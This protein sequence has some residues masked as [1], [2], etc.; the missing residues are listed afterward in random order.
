MSNYENLVKDYPSLYGNLY[1][2]CG[3]GWYQILK[4]LSD[5]I[6]KLDPE[7]K[8]RVGQVKEKFG[9]LRYY[10]DDGG[11]ESIY[12]AITKA[13]KLSEFTCEVCGQPGKERPSGWIKTLC[14]KHAG[15]RNA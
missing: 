4:D 11:S 5:E 9:T 6:T 1:F 7:N 8:V 14:D 2:E 3:E 10:L 12:K 13:E 15:E